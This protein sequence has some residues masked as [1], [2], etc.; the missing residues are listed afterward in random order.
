MHRSLADF[1]AMGGYARFVW[2]A[3]SAWVV[4]IVAN[5]FAARHSLR[6]A[7]EQTRRQLAMRDS[8]RSGRED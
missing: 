6:V 4:V 5:V 8:D 1:L 2:S 3:Y 7:R